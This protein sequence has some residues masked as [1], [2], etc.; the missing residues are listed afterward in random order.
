[1]VKGAVKLAMRIAIRNGAAHCNKI[2][3]APYQ[4]RS[5]VLTIKDSLKNWFEKW[6]TVVENNPIRNL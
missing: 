4:G 2:I 3:T 5:I 1:M 6:D